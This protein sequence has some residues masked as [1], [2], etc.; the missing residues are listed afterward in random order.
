MR[1]PFGSIFQLT[2][3][4]A[5]PWLSLGPGWAVLAGA[6]STGAIEIRSTALLQL[7]AVWVLADPILGML[8]ELSVQQGVWRHLMPGQLPAAS[9]YGFY[10]PYAQPGSVAGQWVVRAR[11][12][13]QW[14]REH[15]WPEQ[16]TQ[17]LT[18]GLGAGLGLLISLSFGATL[19][20]LTLLALA[21]IILAG[22]TQTDLFVAEGG[23][24]Q[25]LIQFLLPWVMGAVLRSTLAPLGLV[26]AL[27]Y[28][29]TYLGGLRMLGG[30][31]RADILFWLG[32]IA[33]ILL[34]LALRQLPG[35]VILTVLFIAQQLIR[36]KFSQ[37]AVFLTKA[38]PYLVLS[39]LV[40][41]WSLGSL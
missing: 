24:V 3:A 2:L 6:W 30:H 10:L 33:A 27:C 17:L 13:G 7:L 16:G 19:F 31:H 36:T 38:Q 20:W 28:W 37:P 41:G 4:P 12:Y 34:L 29:A 26:L 21:L 8:W 23:R 18:F 40:A 22:L 5:R 1:Q 9:H 39:L 32:Q 15:F 11:R 14:W 35:A 25:S